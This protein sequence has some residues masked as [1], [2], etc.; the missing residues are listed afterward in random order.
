[1]DGFKLFEGRMLASH[2]LLS[3]DVFG[4]L[5]K[6]LL[7]VRNTL[8]EWP[9]HA[10]SRL[11]PP[12]SSCRMNAGMAIEFNCPDCSAVIRVADVHSGKRGSC[13]KCSTKLIVP[14]VVPPQESIEN[15][16]PEVP[17]PSLVSPVSPAPPRKTQTSEPET[18]IPSFVA[19]AAGQASISKKLK[20]KTRR[21]KSQAL[22]TWG[23]P[24]ACLVL[25]FSVVAGLMHLQKPE[26][27]GILRG[28]MMHG[29]EI[30]IASSSWA[31][32]ALTESE[33]D[34]AKDAFDS[35]PETLVSA[36][37]SCRI[38]SAD[39][40]LDIEFKIGSG[41]AWFV[42]N[43]SSDVVLSDWIIDNANWL[44]VRRVKLMKASGTKLCKEKIQ[45]S[46][47]D[48]VAFSADEFRDQFAI[49]SHVKAFG[50][51][52][53]AIG[54][55]KRSFCFHEDT[56]GTLYF[57]LPETIK[58]FTLRGR[59]ENGELLFP[60]EYTIKLESFPQP[61]GDSQQTEAESA[62]SEPGAQ[63][64]SSMNSEADDEQ[65]V[66]LDPPM[67]MEDSQ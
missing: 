6:R 15:A 11:L 62:P 32:F 22:Y 2:P 14:D 33:R 10:K 20:R 61:G 35:A 52:V 63:S 12:K 1:M 40:G 49:N 60:G 19:P 43:P 27:K 54:G 47:G 65:P 37:M 44:N 38:R 53:E 4:T 67:M 58:E 66:E 23:I 31:N 29:A 56:N 26:L 42:I 9:I 8:S 59:T 41:F 50:S 48:P 36:Q 45:K 46:S 34:A 55:G 28:S 57:G 18:A 13:P 7:N 21:R 51:A 5:E 39:N 16:S 30:P 64:Q 25:F 24:V 17:V 3:P